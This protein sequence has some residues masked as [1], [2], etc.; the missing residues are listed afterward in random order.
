MSKQEI[1]RHWD[2]N[3]C[4]YESHLSFAEMDSRRSRRYPYLEKELEVW[5]DEDKTIL[6][7]GVG[8]ASD[9]CLSLRTAHPKTYV[10]LDISPRTSD[11][12]KSHLTEHCPNGEFEVLVGDAENMGFEDQEFDRVKAIGSL[13]HI[14]DINKVWRE[15]GRVLKV[16]GD[17]VCLLYHRDSFRNQ[18]LFPWRAYRRG[19]STQDIILGVDGM[20]NPFTRT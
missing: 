19:V 15:I 11:V 2:A 16:G 1:Q 13:H 12:A 8:S 14:P 6:E 10:L 17:F 20:R 9:A 4:D 5:K 18:F 7:I 3:V